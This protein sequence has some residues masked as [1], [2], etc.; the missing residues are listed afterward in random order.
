LR[1]VCEKCGL[2]WQTP[3][4]YLVLVIG[5]YSRAYHYFGV[6]FYGLEVT[7]D[8]SP[9][10]LELFLKKIMQTEPKVFNRLFADDPELE[11]KIY[12]ELTGASLDEGDSW[13]FS[14]SPKFLDWVPTAEIMDRILAGRLP[15][16]I[17]EIWDKRGEPVNLGSIRT[18]E[19]G[20]IMY[21][22]IKETHHSVADS[23]ET[24]FETLP[25]DKVKLDR[26][27]QEKCIEFGFKYNL[28]AFH[29]IIDNYYY[30]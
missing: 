23:G 15:E 25:P 20:R 28:P 19:E 9:R 2:P 10:D 24:A 1:A 4:F 16:F 26:L 12:E 6:F 14:Y 30:R 13:D 27:L 3:Q 11:L 8:R 5:E 18:R 17:N 7:W 21:L 29:L 22:S